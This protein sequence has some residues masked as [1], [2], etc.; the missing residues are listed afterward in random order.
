MGLNT[1]A[2]REYLKQALSQQLPADAMQ[3][4]EEANAKCKSGEERA[5][6]L[7]I[8]LVVRKIEKL[9][10]ELTA[11]QIAEANFIYFSG[12]KPSYLHETLK[13]SLA[14]QAVEG[15]GVRTAQHDGLAD[16]SGGHAR[17]VGKDETCV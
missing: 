17:R 6:N 5:L 3:W 2:C 8:S 10:L 4:L 9:E 11:D 15:A 14:W 13:D 1:E 16:V 7:A 12:G